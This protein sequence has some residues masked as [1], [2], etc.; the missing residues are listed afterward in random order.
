[1]PFLVAICSH[2][3]QFSLQRYAMA[4]KRCQLLY[5]LQSAYA[6]GTVTPLNHDE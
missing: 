6:R 4:Y 2:I 1:M 3:L 5:Q